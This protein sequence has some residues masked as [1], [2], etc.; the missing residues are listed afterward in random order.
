MRKTTIIK[1]NDFIRSRARNRRFSM[2]LNYKVLGQ[3]EPVIILHGL[4]GLL[5]NWLAFGK[6]LSSD[7]TV[8]LLDL[9]NHGRSNHIPEM[10]YQILADTLKEFMENH[11]IYE[12]AIL[13]HSMGGKVAMQVALSYPDL[14]SKLVVFDIAPKKYAPSHDKILMALLDINLDRIQLRSQIEQEL[15]AEI[16]DPGITSFLTKNIQ[17][18]KDGRFDWKLNL[19]G[20]TN[21]YRNLL[22]APLMTDLEY[23]KETVFFRGALSPYISMADVDLINTYFPKAV[24]E[25]IPNA[26]HW[27]HVD[28]FDILL[29][30]VRKFL[31]S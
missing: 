18:T 27:L 14:V 11:W 8:F 15:L 26:G 20:I 29:E 31:F 30:Q 1:E 6:Q 21:S 13:G 16:K 23:H 5:D 24:I 12:A 2:N 10:N 25:T 19:E 3:G 4:F 17:R 9:P 28:A 7:Y 22:E